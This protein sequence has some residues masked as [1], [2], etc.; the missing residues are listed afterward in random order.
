MMLSSC[1]VN[2]ENEVTVKNLLAAFECEMNVHAKYIAFAA[3]AENE[4]LFEAASLFRAIARSGEINAR[5]HARVIRKL[6]AEPEARIHTIE[7]KTTL[8]NLAT[9]LDNEVYEIDSMYPR[10]L[11]DNRS[12][13]NSAAR[14]FTWALEAKKTRARLL[15]QI[16][17]QTDL[18]K[19]SSPT[20]AAPEYYV[21]PVCGYVSRSHE[22]ERCWVCEHFC[23]T[24][25][26]I[27]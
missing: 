21:R 7:V 24:F 15:T 23:K 25:E 12:T 20:G 9:A 22:P 26:A 27:Q 2:T 5:N 19:G 13:D 1:Y 4:C 8:E 3:E 18:G 17:K 14:S 10:F 16:I 11:A 6:G